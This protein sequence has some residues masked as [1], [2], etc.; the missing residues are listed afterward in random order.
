VRRISGANVEQPPARMLL[1]CLRDREDDVLRF[2]SDLRI[3][4]TS[5]GD[6]Q[7]LRPAQANITLVPYGG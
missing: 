7:D 6:E 5:N 1:E 2:L 3:P 4:P